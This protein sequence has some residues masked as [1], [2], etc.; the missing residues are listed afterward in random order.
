MANHQALNT[1]PG[2]KIRRQYFNVPIYMILI[3]CTPFFVIFTLFELPADPTEA[4]QVQSLTV[5]V[6][7]ILLLILIP[8]AV[9][10]ALNRFCFGKTVCVLNEKGLYFFDQKVRCILWS[11]IKEVAYEPDL[12]SSKRPFRHPS[13]NAIHITT[14]PFKK[15]ITTTITEVPFYLLGRMK[16][17]QPNAKYRVKKF[18]I[19]FALLMIVLPIIIAMCSIAFS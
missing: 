7:I 10:S 19:V 17:Y 15:T 8:L 5:A 6:L 9:L 2:E 1:I 13:Y 12:P 11:D 3:H 14:K 4:A 18:C 16:K